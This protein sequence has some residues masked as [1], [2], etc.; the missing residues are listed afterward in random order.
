MPIK[1]GVIMDPI[2]SIRFA[3][4]ST[5]A[6]LLAAKA[7]GFELYYMQMQDIYSRQGQVYA[8]LARIDVFNDAAHYFDK[9][10]QQTMPLNELDVIL[11]RMDPPV[12]QMYWYTT[13]LLD[14][15]EKQGTLVINKPSSLRDVN[16]KLFINWFPEC[17]PP[18]LFS[19]HTKDIIEFIKTQQQAILKPLHGM[20]GTSIFRVN[21][22]DP[23]THVIIETL[24]KMG[25]QLCCVQR[26]I[27]EIAQG[28]KRILMINGEPIPYALARIP[29]QGDFRGNLAAGA[30]NEGREL[31]VRDRAICDIVSPVL[32]EKGLFFVG[33][34][35]I[36]DYLT[37][38]NVTSA[39]CIRELDK[40]YNLDISGQIMT[41]IEEILK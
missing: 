3:K 38:I 26:F 25:T 20:G 10:P 5:L 15:V 1:L 4:D 24:T 8:H 11:V 28:D 2:E 19:A 41:Q 18:T 7:R 40:W 39:T 12:E 9:A 6:M 32:K 14:L 33:L 21:A 13:Q 30:S 16:E 35:I 29:A 23:N 36:G 31:T 34:D 27:P 22:G 37:E 17:C